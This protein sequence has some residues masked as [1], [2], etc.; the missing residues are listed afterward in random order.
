MIHIFYIERGLT[1]SQYISF[2]GI[3]FGI[4]LLLE[5][6]FGI[7]ADKYNKKMLLLISNILF[8]TSTIVFINSYSY[9]SFLIAI[10]INAMNNSL[11]SGIVNSILYE[12]IRDKHKFKKLLFYNSFFY[13]VSY[14]IAMIIGGY[15]GQKFGLVYTYYI[16]IIPFVID[17]IIL[18][19]IKTN[20]TIKNITIENNVSIL[21]NGIKEVVDNTYLLNLMLTNAV[22][23]SGIKLMEE[24]H[25][26]YSANIGISVFII[27]IYTSIILLFCIIGSYIG[28][29]VKTEKYQFVLN[30]F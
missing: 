18:L 23:F 6:P 3:A 2:V 10:V 26:E 22:F 20:E 16:T 11:N 17:F 14:M 29:K 21:K 1:S 19:M 27:G 28:S 4:R 25:P 30:L 24:S 15:I 7:I 9:Y 12:S 5:I 8:I 13:N